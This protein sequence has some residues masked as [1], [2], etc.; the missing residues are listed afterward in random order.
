MSR[1][2]PSS[3]LNE[4]IKITNGLNIFRKFTVFII[5]NANTLYEIQISSSESN[6]KLFKTIFPNPKTFISFTIDNKAV[7]IMHLQIVLSNW[8]KKLTFFPPHTCISCLADSIDM[9]F[10]SNR[11][12]LCKKILWLFTWTNTHFLLAYQK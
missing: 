9:H 8:N 2:H 6:H 4:R 12:K 5:L 3:L 10:K 7:W 11:C 1:K